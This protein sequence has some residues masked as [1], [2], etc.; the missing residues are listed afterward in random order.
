MKKVIRTPDFPIVR[1]KQGKLHGYQ[2][3]DVFHFYGIRYGRAER[4]QLPEPEPKW[5]G[6]RDAKSYGY[7]CPLMPEEEQQEDS[8]MSAPGNSFEMQHVYWPMREQCLYLNVWTKH[9]W[10]KE[11][12]EVFGGDPDNVTVAG[13]SGGGG[14]AAILMQMPLAD[15]LY[16]KVISQ[17]GALRDRSG[18]NITDEKRHWQSLGEKTAEIL[19]LTKENI[20]TID[21]IPYEELAKAAVQAGK[22]LGLPGGMLLFEPS[23]T[24]GFYEGLA[25]IVGFREETKHIPV[26]AGTVLGEFAFMHYLGD[27]TRYTEVDKYNILEQNYGK[28][29]MSIIKQFRKLYPGMDILYALSVDTLFR[30]QTTAFLDRRSEFTKAKCYNYMMNVIIPY[31]GGLA[32]WL[33]ADIPYVFRNVEMEPAHCTGYQYAEKL[34]DQISKAWIAFMK[35]GNPSTRSLKWSPYTKEHP[36]RMIFAEECGMEERDDSRLLKLISESCKK[37]Y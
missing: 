35:K 21:G 16:H 6:I 22:E 17:S 33:C 9:Q 31:L 10:V 28:N 30:P 2:E 32:P 34:Q 29:T 3:D 5:D 25:S 4:F 14:K 7:I 12:I 20:E 19:G 18:T 1:T 11:N 24:E 26:M 23:P 27:K 8:P 37:K 36:D 15:G 13:Q